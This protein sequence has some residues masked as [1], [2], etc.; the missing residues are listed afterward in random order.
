MDAQVAA[1]L[2]AGNPVTFS[3]P[4]IVVS[5]NKVVQRTCDVDS[6]CSAPLHTF[7]VYTNGIF[8]LNVLVPV[9]EYDVWITQLI[10]NVVS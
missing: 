7:S 6:S 5:F 2:N 9:V 3:I 10:N 4:L 1:L 8:G